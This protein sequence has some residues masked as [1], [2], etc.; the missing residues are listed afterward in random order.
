VASA[1]EHA[2]Q[3]RSSK[4][5]TPDARGGDRRPR[6]PDSTLRG[7]RVAARF[8]AGTYPIEAALLEPRR[9]VT[10]NPHGIPLTR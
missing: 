1:G 5:E 6:D 7:L 8:P 2:A 9:G 10:I 3:A 4:G